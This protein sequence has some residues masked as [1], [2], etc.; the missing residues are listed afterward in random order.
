M[1]AD[2]A[3][4]MNSPDFKLWLT[5]Q[6]DGYRDK[7]MTTQ[8]GTVVAAALTKFKSHRAGLEA[9]AQRAMET[10]NKRAARTA[11]SVTHRSGAA[12]GGG[13]DAADEGLAA[14]EA[15]FKDDR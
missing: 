9:S 10:A 1:H 6:G 13:R 11:G 7:V 3:P 12:P 15:A 8:S 5:T 14:F 2:W 4:T